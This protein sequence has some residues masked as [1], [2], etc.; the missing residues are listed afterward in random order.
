MAPKLQDGHRIQVVPREEWTPDLRKAAMEA[1]YM[2]R[3]Q[4][5]DAAQDILSSSEEEGLEELQAHREALKEWTEYLLK[6]QEAGEPRGWLPG[7]ARPKSPFPW[8]RRGYASPDPEQEWGGAAS[9]TA[10]DSAREQEEEKGLSRRA[11]KN[12]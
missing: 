12:S 1:R 10:A 3:C 9:S 8:K 6:W 4:F 5:P 11:K 2:F 7:V